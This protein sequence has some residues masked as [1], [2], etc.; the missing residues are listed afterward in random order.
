M[1]KYNLKMQSWRINW[2][3]TKKWRQSIKRQIS[4]SQNSMILNRLTNW[5]KQ[6][7]RLRKRMQPKCHKK[8]SQ[9]NYWTRWHVQEW[10]STDFKMWQ[11]SKCLRWDKNDRDKID[12]RFKL[13]IKP[14]TPNQNFYRLVPLLP[15][16]FWHS[17]D[18]LSLG[19]QSTSVESLTK[20]QS[21]LLC[22]SNQILG[23]SAPR[24]TLAPYQLGCDPKD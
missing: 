17:L 15:K 24:L 10:F 4:Y 9:A 20:N 2:K 23:C 3:R 11:S 21:C 19:L 16:C 14:L 12:P 6:S 7:S 13:M 8:N 18:S 5:S 22:S 1:R